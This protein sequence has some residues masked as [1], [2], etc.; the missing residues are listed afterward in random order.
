MKGILV[1]LQI[2]L[3]VLVCACNKSK[4]VPSSLTPGDSQALTASFARLEKAL[5]ARAPSLLT[6]FAPAASSIEI[7]N[8]RSALGGVKIDALEAW[9]GWRNGTTNRGAFLLPLGRPLSITEAIEDRKMIRDV[10]FVDKLRKSS[11]MIMEDGA[12]DGF[13]LDITTTNP[14]VF[15]H[16]LEDPTPQSYGTLAEFVNFIASGFEQKILFLD[17]NGKVT[18]NEGKYQAFEDAHFKSI[19]KR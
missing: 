6:N 13:L 11:I 10:P 8:L 19:K 9:F 1:S 5:A 12:G 18:E 17:E 3:L 14:V 15:Y 7:T 16:M 2:G 4:I